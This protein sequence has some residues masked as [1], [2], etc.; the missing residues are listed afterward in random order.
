M[1]HRKITR[2]ERLGKVSDQAALMYSWIIPYMDDYYYYSA[3]PVDIKA[4][5]F[6]R[7]DHIKTEDIPA[8]L[9]ELKNVGLIVTGIN[10]KGKMVMKMTCDKSIQTFR[11]DRDRYNDYGKIHEKE[12]FD[13][14]PVDV[15]GIPLTVAREEKVREVKRR[16]EKVLVPPPTPQELM[17]YWNIKIEGLTRMRKVQ[18]LSDTRR[19]KIRA[20]GKDEFFNLY[21]KESI[22][23][24]ALS[25]YLTGRN[26][27]KRPDDKYKKWVADFD[28]FIENG[29]SITKI[30][31]G[32]YDNDKPVSGGK[33]H[34]RMQR[35][36]EAMERARDAANKKG[37]TA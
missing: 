36:R 8:L 30:M 2:N 18:S 37:D 34:E 5:I 9:A 4:D 3:D 1:I 13:D 35:S 16:E 15:S 14:M 26:I 32:K 29:N 11:S 22:D 33:Y 17:D 6:R 25:D 10:D 7:R 31:E 27:N 24:I 28:W 21:W 12:L 20:R 23:K 19:S